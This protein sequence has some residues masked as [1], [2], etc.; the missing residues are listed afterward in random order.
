MDQNH[1]Q[2]ILEKAKMSTPQPYGDGVKRELNLNE[3]AVPTTKTML[4]KTKD[5]QHTKK[6]ILDTVTDLGKQTHNATFNA[7]SGQPRPGVQLD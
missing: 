5:K 4:S 3:T 2:K 7:A 1:T 6:K